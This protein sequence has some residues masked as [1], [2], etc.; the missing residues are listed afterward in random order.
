MVILIL[1]QPG[2]YF[3]M[4]TAHEEILKI[5]NLALKQLAT[6]KPLPEIFNTL[7]L[8]AEKNVEGAIASIL[9][10]DN[11]G[12]RLIDGSTP[13]FSQAM[14][15]AFN[16]MLIGP[17]EGSCGAAAYSKQLVIVEDITT[18]PR[19]EKFKDF[20]HSQGLKSCYSG[21]IIGSDD[22]VLGTFALT[23]IKAKSPTDIELEIIQSSAHIAGLAIER[24]RYEENL[25]RYAKEL[26]DF[27]SIA[28]HDLQE[29]LR[30]IVAFGDRLSS[31]ISD[32]DEQSRNYLGRMQ[33]AALRMR[34][35]IDD[36]LQFSKIESNEKS[37]EV[38]DLNKVIRNVLDDLEARVQETKGEINLKSLPVIEADPVQMHQLFL[39]L[40]GNALKF[41]RE[42]V[43]PVISL[44]TTCKGDGRCVI[45][46]EDNG[47]GIE[48]DLVDKIFKPFERLHGRSVYEGTGIGLTICNKIVARHGGEIRV[49]SGSN[50]VTFHI[51]LPEKQKNSSP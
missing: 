4:H 27:S 32:S 2:W 8:G 36:L 26:E 15:D 47:I 49:E 41:H 22:N 42:G 37:Y 16:G 34:K 31:R 40:I 39:N 3:M 5:Q 30:K 19:W 48:E 7:T 23:F 29:P 21:P 43:P 45:M 33:S 20:A 25:Q 12:T 50:G 10:L 46:V 17:L 38:I 28:S 51:I 1:F 11:P 9:L 6:G 14:K 35:L 13:N 44:D 18:D 24:K